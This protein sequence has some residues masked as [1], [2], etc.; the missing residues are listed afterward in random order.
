MYEERLINMICLYEKGLTAREEVTVDKL[1]GYL[2]IRS[3]KGEVVSQKLHDQSAVFVGFFSQR[4]QLSDCFFK[5]LSKMEIRKLYQSILEFK[6][7][8]LFFFFCCRSQKSEP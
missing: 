8:F 6:C 5:S 3:P 2:G 1:I 4:I 7:L